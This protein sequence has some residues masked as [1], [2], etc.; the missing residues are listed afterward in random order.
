MIKREGQHLIRREPGAALVDDAE[1]VGIAIEPEPELGFAAANEPAHLGHAFGVRFGM[2]PA[3]QRI[4]FIVENGYPRRGFLQQSV[5]IAAAGAKHQLDGDFK[6]GLPDGGKSDQL[7]QLFEIGR[8]RINGLAPEG[9]HDSRLESP[10]LRDQPGDVRLDLLR[11]FRRRGRAIVRREFQAL[12]FGGI[13]AGRQ[14]DAPESL[15]LADG[16]G[17]HRGG[18]VPIAQQ[19]GEPAGRQ[20]FRRCQREFAPEKTRVV[21]DNDDRPA[22]VDR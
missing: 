15:S 20:H 12:I 10:V 21:T 7:A 14:V 22:I 19:G 13:V 18:R 2:V 4:Q 6:P 9:S 11:H 17:D 5:Q 8:L 16:V 3:E 1:A